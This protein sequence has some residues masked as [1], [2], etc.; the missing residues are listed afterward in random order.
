MP[1][2]PPQTRIFRSIPPS[3]LRAALAAAAFGAAAGLRAQTDYTSLSLEELSLVP[4]T[5]LGREETTVED[6]PAAAF[7]VTGDDIHRTGALDF[8][9][10]LRLVPG[11]QVAQIDSV[12]Y[13]ISIRGFNDWTSSKV[14]VLIDGR[15]IYSTAFTGID[16]NYYDL[17]LADTARIEVLRGPGA[18]L[19]GANAMD[20]VINVVSKSAADTLGTLVSVAAGDQLDTSTLVRQGWQF[21]PNSA[22]RVY[23]KYQE[24]GSYGA[25]DGPGEGGWD[26]RLVGSRYDWSGAGGQALTLIGEIRYLRD[27]SVSEFPSL[28]PPDYVTTQNEVERTQGGNLSARYT[29]PLPHGGEASLL[30]SYEHFDSSEISYGEDRDTYN[31][32]LQFTLHPGPR[33]EVIAGGTYREDRDALTSSPWM[34]YAVPRAT[35]VFTGVFVQDEL[36]VL[37]NRLTV[38]AGTKDERNSFSGW[39]LQPSLRAIARPSRTQRIW[40]GVSRAARTPSLAERYVDWLAA[41]VPPEPPYPVPVA[42]RALGSGQFG[43]EHLDAYELGYRYDPNVHL[44]VDLALYRNQYDNLRSLV[45]EPA[46]FALAPIP[47]LE[48]DYTVGNGIRGAT[49]GGEASVRWRPNTQWSVEGSASTISYRLDEASPGPAPDPTIA[50]LVGSTPHEEYKLRVSW[51]PQPRWSAD[52]VARYTGPLNG[53]NIPGYTGLD[54]RLA[55]KPRPDLEIEA[56]GRNLLEPRHAEGSPFFIGGTGIQSIDRSGFLRVTYRQ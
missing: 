9:E 6:T 5:T 33:N 18:S 43:S 14:L 48:Q 50:G 34:S 25:T 37:P 28:L 12:D 35:T 1:D 31:A 8:A 26:T 20:G 51:D 45:A 17:D 29:L 49:E 24:Q 10:A 36:T 23:A 27:Y 32:D 15:P 42:I 16:W 47:H 46:E 52:A 38:T 41:V 11:M 19:W 39:E 30:T 56:V 54:L 13:A 55:W 7:V 44:S 22:I 21:T 3:L 53:E 2:T 40:V 4:I